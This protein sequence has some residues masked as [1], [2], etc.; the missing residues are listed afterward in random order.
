MAEA[1]VSDAREGAW[2]SKAEEGGQYFLFSSKRSR[3]EDRSSPRFKPSLGTEF[4]LD[5]SGCADPGVVMAI[6]GNERLIAKSLTRPVL[7]S[8]L[9]AA[10]IRERRRPI[11]P[12]SVVVKV[13]SFR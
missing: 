13:D 2:S 6:G 12:T 3:S 10:C 5:G 9:F 4:M 1:E 7:E 11:S 8:M